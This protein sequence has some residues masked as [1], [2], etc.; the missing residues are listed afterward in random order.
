MYVIA[1]EKG[2]FAHLGTSAELLELLSFV[3]DTVCNNLTNLE[4]GRKDDSDKKTTHINKLRLFS[5]KY[6]LKQRIITLLFSKQ[7]DVNNIHSRAYDISSKALKGISL[8][9]CFDIDGAST[10]CDRGSFIEHSILKGDYCIGAGAIVSHVAGPLGYNLTLLP[11]MMIQFIPLISN[12]N[13][14]ISEVGGAS[15]KLSV[16]LVLGVHDDV[17]AY[18]RSPGD[19]LYLLQVNKEVS[20]AFIFQYDS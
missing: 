12:I 1:V 20:H 6:K 7:Y 18:Y 13:I 15:T 4:E 2:N 5:N 14:T 11:N 8:N 19:D 9:S 10:L 17:K 16:L 3:E